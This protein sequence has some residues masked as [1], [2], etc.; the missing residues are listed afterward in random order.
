[1]YSGKGISIS[2]RNRLNL[3]LCNL[4]FFLI[5][6]FIGSVIQIEYHMHGLPETYSV[7]AFDKS[8]WVLLHKTSAVVFFAGL[9][10]HCLVNWRFVST[11]TT[12]I[13][14]GKPKAFSSHS[15]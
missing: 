2:T 3:N 7:M 14:G 11:S 4:V 9:V 12:R 13:F 5:V 8:G 15:Y 10:V 6:A 1:M